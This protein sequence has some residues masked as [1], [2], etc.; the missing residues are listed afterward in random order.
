MKAGGWRKMRDKTKV[1]TGGGKIPL[2]K[3]CETR[4]KGYIRGFT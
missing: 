1:K 2:W 3:G 4:K